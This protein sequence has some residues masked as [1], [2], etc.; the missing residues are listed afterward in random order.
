MLQGYRV[1]FLFRGNILGYHALPELAVPADQGRL[2]KGRSS[3]KRGGQL[4]R[5]LPKNL[6]GKLTFIDIYA[7]AARKPKIS[8]KR[9]KSEKRIYC[10]LQYTEIYGLW[11]HEQ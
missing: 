4:H 3:D 2:A 6:Q 8:E 5:H 10:Q 9:E 1:C 11:P 7:K